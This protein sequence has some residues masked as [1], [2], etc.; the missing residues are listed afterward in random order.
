MAPSAKA[1]IGSNQYVTK[2]GTMPP[3]RAATSAIAAAV[4]S[5]NNIEYYSALD[6]GWYE[7][8]IAADPWMFHATHP[9]RVSDIMR[10][11][12]VP[13]D[14]GAGIASDSIP[15]RTDAVYLGE[16]STIGWLREWT[17]GDSPD[18]QILIAV[19]MR[20]IQA[21]RVVPDEDTL[22]PD[23][24]ADL[25][26]AEFGLPD[27]DPARWESPGRWAQDV[28]MGAQPGI[29]E[30]SWDQRNTIAV[31]GAIPPDALIVNVT[32]DDLPTG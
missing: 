7:A 13:Q 24:G 22:N 23:M 26:P 18:S 27:F 6:E 15:A 1:G 32:E 10:N 2:P 12:L 31:L 5:P 8:K 29:V 28:R 25:S 30:A 20:R 3:N 16:R 21:A 19:D 11:G 9:G 4:S 17:Y 14:H